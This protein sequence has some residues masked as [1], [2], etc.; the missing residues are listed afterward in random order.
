MLTTILKCKL[1]LSKYI[2]N[3]RVNSLKV[4]GSISHLFQ[5]PLFLPWPPNF[6]VYVQNQILYSGSATL[7]V[8]RFKIRV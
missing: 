8:T 1:S 5:A 7:Q 3:F 2:P 4:P 6:A